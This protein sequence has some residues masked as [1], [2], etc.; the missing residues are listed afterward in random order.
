[1][2]VYRLDREKRRQNVLTGIGAERMGGRWN[3]KGTKTVYTSQ[4][5]ALAMLEV[6]VHIDI[7]DLPKDMILAEIHIPD[8]IEI[9]SLK[10]LPTNWD[11]FPYR[12]EVQKTFTAFCHKDEAA[13]L[14]VPSAIVEGEFNF[15]INPLHKDFKKI[16]T[17]RIEA[18]NFDQRLNQYFVPSN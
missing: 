18:L 12:F 15:L 1:M 11:K 7:T 3:L 4:S 9:V 13:V 6:L 17:I 5:R 2:I 16:K 14:K 10:K 8:S